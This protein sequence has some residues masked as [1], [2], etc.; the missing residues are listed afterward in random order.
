LGGVKEIVLAAAL[1]FGLFLS[2]LLAG[3]LLQ[4]RALEW[5]LIATLVVCIPLSA[6]AALAAALTTHMAQFP[7]FLAVT[8]G[9]GIATY[10][11]YMGATRVIDGFVNAAPMIRQV[12]Y[13]LALGVAIAVCVL[14]AH[15]AAAPQGVAA[16]RT[17]PTGSSGR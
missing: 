4:H 14:L 9:S 16:D 6:L 1:S 5:F 12:P 17:R 13:S 2:L 15:I 7:R 11:G 3:L 8:L 10:I